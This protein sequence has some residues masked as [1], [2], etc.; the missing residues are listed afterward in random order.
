[1]FVGYDAINVQMDAFL[2]MKL[3]ERTT[4]KIYIVQ[5]V[6]KSIMRHAMHIQSSKIAIQ[7][8]FFA[9]HAFGDCFFSLNWLDCINFLVV[10]VGD[11]AV[12][13]ADFNS[14]TADDI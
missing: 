3:L 8:R 5:N 6:I 14:T 11:V 13:H 1:M 2:W 7:T 12:R 10:V 9:F 4:H